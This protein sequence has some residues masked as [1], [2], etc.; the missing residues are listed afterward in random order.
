MTSDWPA[1]VP[2][3]NQMPDLRCHAGRSE[4]AFTHYILNR[5]VSVCFQG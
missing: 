5:P 2:P 1:A 4:R 3:A